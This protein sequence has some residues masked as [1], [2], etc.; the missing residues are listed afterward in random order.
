[1]KKS[2]IPMMLSLMLCLPQLSI[3]RPTMRSEAVPSDDQLTLAAPGMAGPI[4]YK[5]FGHFDG[6]GTPDYHY[7]ITDKKGLSDAAGEGIFPYGGV[8]RDPAFKKLMQDKAL[9]GNQWKFVDGNTAAKNFYKWVSTNDDPGVKQFY[10]A[11]MLERAGL[12]ETAVKAFYAVAV[13]FPKTISYTYY[14]TPWYVGAASL[15]R[16]EQILRRHPELK[17]KLVG[18]RIAI[19]NRYDADPKNDEFSIDPGKLVAVKK[20]EKPKE[21]NVEKMKVIKTVGGPRFQLKEYKNRHWRFFV[22]GKPFPIRAITYSVTPVGRSP[23][24]GNWDV[25]KDWQIVDTDNDGRHD[26]F[27]QSYIDLNGNNKRDDNEPI[28]GDAKIISDLGANTLRA[29]HHIYNK[30]LFRKLYKEHGIYILCG[31]LLGGYAVGSGASWTDGTDY[32]N[33]TQQENM[34]KSVREM[35]TENK[36]EP[37]ILMWVLGNENVYGV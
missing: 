19:K 34:L 9:E 1:M 14:D 27:E 20:P 2:L 24:R 13:H 31:D 28:V 22:D 10:V 21:V 37:Y 6:V 35:V 32:S 33:P 18:G 8:F 15:D 11:L 3:A 36:D 23:D 26:G 4:P 25:S 17:M 29:Y 12:L 5:K 30:E 7:V 16:V